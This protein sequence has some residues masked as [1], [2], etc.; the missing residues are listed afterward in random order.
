MLQ[1]QIPSWERFI[2]GEADIANQSRISNG[3]LLVVFNTSNAQ[4]NLDMSNVI[5][6]ISSDVA[7]IRSQGDFTGIKQAYY[8]NDL[9]KLSPN[10]QQG[11]KKS[12]RFVVKSIDPSA[13]VKKINSRYEPVLKNDLIFIRGHV[14]EV[15]ESVASI[16]NV[17]YIG[18]ESISPKVETPVIDLNLRP[19]QVNIVH[20]KSPELTGEGITL[21]IHEE[22]FDPHDI[23]FS[24]RVIDYEGSSQNISRHATEMT[25]IAAGAGN[26]FITGL[27]V[28]KRAS[29][30]S[31]DFTDIIPDPASF[32]IDY[33]ISVQNHSFGTEIENFYGAIAAEYDENVNEINT[34]VH[35][36]S[37]G[38][39]GFDQ[40]SEGIY[41]G[42]PGIANLT[43]NYKQAKNVLTVGSADTVFNFPEFVSRGPA[44][45]GRIKPEFVTYSNIGSSNS[46]AILSGICVLLQQKYLQRYNELP[47]FSTVKSIL[48]ASA[49]DVGIPG[50]DYHSG[51]G[52]VNAYNAIQITENKDFVI[53]SVANGVT[54]TFQLEIPADV[55]NVRVALSWIDVA[56]NP[57][58]YKA[59]VNDLDIVIEGPNGDLF[60]PG[61]PDP[62]P[63]TEILE[64]NV[65]TGIDTLNNGELITLKDPEPG[66]YTVK[67]SGDLLFG[68]HQAYS[69]AWYK[70][71]K[72][73]FEWYAPVE[74]ENMPYNGESASYFRWNS[75][76]DGAQ[77]QLF[78]RWDDG[79]EELIEGNV[80]VTKGY[81]RWVSP[82]TLASARAIM[83]IDGI[84]YTSE[85]FIISS[86]L[87]PLVTVNCIDSLFI[88]WKPVNG[89]DNYEVLTFD[90]SLHEYRSTVITDDT[91]AIIQ[92]IDESNIFRVFPHFAN[93][94]GISG[95]AIN[96]QSQVSTCFLNSF[97]AQRNGNLKGIDLTIFL[98]SVYGIRELQFFRTGLEDKL[99]GLLDKDQLTSKTLVLIDENPA[100]GMNNYYARLIFE[101]GQIID[102]EIAT[103]YYFNNRPGMIFPNPARAGEEVKIFT[104]SFSDRHNF[105]LLSTT[106]KVIFERELLPERDFIRINAIPQGVYIYKVTGA[107]VNMTGKLIIY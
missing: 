24:N 58:D 6:K 28:A 3:F 59:L 10:V 104:R 63:G 33:N 19:N 15:I 32:Y 38:N 71:R 55:R 54:R 80:D 41:N 85:N 96:T 76:L 7:I 95:Q 86:P 64:R 82:D 67:I 20:Q 69:I 53:D 77:G 14:D 31:S 98:G 43:G 34:L 72:N 83:R 90:P 4:D 91:F 1:A 107:E 49:D 87:R 42:I 2:V 48:M 22:K 75:T 36:F 21:S 29:L 61:V 35:V 27:G 18:I 17:F 12:Y 16:T 46:A 11:V 92:G 74:N 73:L 94:R 25:T 101:N 84:D 45:D 65:S 97:F 105:S 37:S 106:G 100:E 68:D 52:S 23:D 47:I 70:E 26:S 9:W 79:R 44:Y 57:G 89:A 103:E 40:A 5:R 78:I 93:H 99:I 66:N 81:Y 30:V 60:Y 56:A 50:P 39:N 102:S 62:T 51:Y 88:E 13:T 8:V